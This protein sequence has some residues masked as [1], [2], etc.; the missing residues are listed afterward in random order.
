MVALGAAL[1]GAVLLAGD[2]GGC[3]TALRGYLQAR[4]NP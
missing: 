1:Y 2:V 4:R 3:R